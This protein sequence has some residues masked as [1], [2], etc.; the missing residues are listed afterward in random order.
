ME[1]LRKAAKERLDELR[2]ADPNARLFQAQLALA[3]EYGFASWRALKAHVDTVS[4]DGQI[5]RAAQEG[6]ADTLAKL[7]DEH[8]AKINITGGSWERPL[9][10]LAAEAGH[11]EAVK[12]LLDRGFDVNKRDKW[13]NATALH[14]AAED[15]R[16][17]VAKRLLDAGAD[18]HGA[19]DAHQA[20]VLGWAVCLGEVRRIGH[21][22]LGTP[23]DDIAAL[24]LAR[25]ARH[26][27]FTA[28]AVND[29]AAVRAI[30]AADPA[31]L[32]ARMSRFEQFR[33]PLHLAVRMNLP[34]MVRLLLAL[35]AD[36][37]ARDG[38]GAAPL[39]YATRTADP[40]IAAA[41]LAAGADPEEAGG[42]VPYRYVTP[43]LSVKNLAASID[44]YVDRLGFRIEFEAGRDF[45]AAMHDTIRIFLVEGAQGQ[46]GT[47]LHIWAL[48]VDAL[49][50]ELKDAG[51]MI[52]NPPRN[53][54]WGDREM[55][56]KDPDGHV[57]RFSGVAR[58]D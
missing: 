40:A 58:E 33:T 3:Q 51:A 47:W 15:G 19:G 46:P 10:H 45:C 2:A 32:D 14:W 23:D 18:V 35:G 50:D 27:I 22:R 42:R 48:D 13:D 9:L 28:V 26:S 37:R 38:D 11:D 7:L 25:G 17:A 1:W 6:K 53:Q 54:P 57:I 34:E 5:I 16:I 56:V 55:D 52:W 49:H 31:A 24:L 8:P 20:G 36:A 39:R 43:I 21:K 4:L 41:L 29:E 30:V 44:Y 12:V